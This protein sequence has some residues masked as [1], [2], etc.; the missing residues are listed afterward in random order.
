MYIPPKYL[1]ILCFNKVVTG[2]FFKPIFSNWLITG[3][4]EVTA[5]SVCFSI[6]HVSS[7]GDGELYRL[8][9]LH[10]SLQNVADQFSGIPVILKYPLVTFGHH[11]YH[12]AELQIGLQQEELEYINNSGIQQMI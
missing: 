11:C 9:S 5:S 12:G 7:T 1:R 10:L 2:C 8:L 4:K 6:L 3:H